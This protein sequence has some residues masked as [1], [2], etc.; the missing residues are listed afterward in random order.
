M[1]RSQRSALVLSIEGG[2]AFFSVSIENIVVL[3]GQETRLYE[4]LSAA[5][6]ASA[7]ATHYLY[8]MIGALPLSNLVEKNSRVFHSMSDRNSN[9]DSAEIVRRLFDAFQTSEFLNL[10]RFEFFAVEFIRGGSQSR[11]HNSA[12]RSEYYAGAGVVADDVVVEVLV[13][14]SVEQNT[15]TLNKFCKFSRRQDG[16]DVLKALRTVVRRR[17]RIRRGNPLSL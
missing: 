10:N 15:R 1:R 8:E 6:D 3:V 2:G 7:G 11:F 16:V 5:G 4:R 14:K 12:R 17:R 13:G 9:L